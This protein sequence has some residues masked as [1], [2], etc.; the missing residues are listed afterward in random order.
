MPFLHTYIIAATWP[1]QAATA[2]WASWARVWA[3]TLQHAGAEAAQNAP[4]D[5]VTGAAAAGAA[6]VTKGAPAPS[7]DTKAR[8]AAKGRGEPPRSDPA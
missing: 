5:P 2:F 3:E 8:K 1:M 7:P 4:T 6:A